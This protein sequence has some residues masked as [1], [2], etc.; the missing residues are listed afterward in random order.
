MHMPHN[1]EMNINHN[2]RE[3]EIRYMKCGDYAEILDVKL[4]HQDK[5]R[6]IKTTE[7][8]DAIVLEMIDNV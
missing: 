3:F 5:A 4:I 7:D 6:S 1:D 2:G 8:F